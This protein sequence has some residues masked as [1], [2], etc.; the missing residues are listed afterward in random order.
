MPRWSR[1]RWASGLVP[2]WR[3]A[4]DWATDLAMT[5]VLVTATTMDLATMSAWAMT[6]GLATMSAKAM[7]SGSPMMSERAM[8]KGWRSGTG[9]PS[10]RFLNL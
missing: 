4:K 3:T 7:A 8:A 1:L 5:T 2:G 9:G 10:C 6:L